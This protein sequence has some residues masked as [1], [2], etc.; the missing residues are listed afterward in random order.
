MKVL[1][2]GGTGVVGKASVDRLLAAGHTVRLLSRHA[3]DDA[4]QWPQGVEP[5]TGDV[6]T[7]EGV[8]GAAD[9]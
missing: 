9:G 3:D 1:V 7:D 6:T 5:R 2:T 8:R 4:R